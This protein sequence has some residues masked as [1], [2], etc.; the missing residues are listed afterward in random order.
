[1]AVILVTDSQYVAI[2]VYT[3][4]DTTL[5]TLI[6]TVILTLTT[7]KMKMLSKAF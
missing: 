1:M 6:E 5:H 4:Y 2:I 7:L 3:Y